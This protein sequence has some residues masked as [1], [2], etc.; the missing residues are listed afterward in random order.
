MIRT[1]EIKAQMKRKGMIQGDLAKR[2]DM[3]PA[4][5]SRKINDTDG[6][7]MTINEAARMCK[8]LDLP[9]EQWSEIFFAEKLT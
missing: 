8:E 6:V 7:K 4:T 3:N 1:N 5:L 9:K 2:M